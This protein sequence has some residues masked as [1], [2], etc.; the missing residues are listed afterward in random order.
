MTLVMQFL[1]Y[2]AR[3]RTDYTLYYYLIEMDGIIGRQ[4]EKQNQNKYN[5][6]M[7][8]II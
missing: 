3:S 2:G 4:L 1:N 7:N 8:R 6:I 5:S